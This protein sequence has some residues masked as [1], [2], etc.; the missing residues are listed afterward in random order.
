MTFSIVAR[1]G[2][3]DE[4]GVAV[5]SKFLAVGAVVGWAQAGA[6][7]I[8]TQAMANVAYGPEGLEM[9][10]TGASASDTLAT[11]VGRDPEKEHRQVGLVDA[12]GGV[13]TFTGSE[14]FDWAG[15]LTGGGYTCQGNILTGPEVMEAMG[16]T[17]ETS[18]GDLTARL[19]A[20]LAAGDQAGGDKRGRQSAAMLVVREGG[21]YGG[22][23]D[24]TVD[25]RVDDHAHPVGELSRLLDIHRLIFPRPEDL[26]FVVLDA[27]L[28]DRVRAALELAG[29][30]AGGDLREA[31]FAYVGTENLEERWSGDE[32]L[33]ETG[34][35]RHL[36]L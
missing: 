1:D 29:W 13:A 34:I 7:A 26:E 30:D 4:W 15:G 23:T 24:V 18:A 36:G 2:A 8:A 22:G 28:A 10:A 27:V 5:A 6:G 31:L 35:L 25:L 16:T 14:C 11:L 21:G 3:T 20:A 9:L 12:V 32:S 19:L 17:F 33:I